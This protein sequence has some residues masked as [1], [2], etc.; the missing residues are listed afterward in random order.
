MPGSD[1]IVV[2]MSAAP[3]VCEPVSVATG[4]SVMGSLYMLFTIGVQAGREETEGGAQVI[5][6][7]VSDELDD[8][9]D[10]DELNDSEEAEL[11]SIG[12]VGSYC[13]EVAAAPL[14]VALSP[15][16]I[17]HCPSGCSGTT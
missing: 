17:G 14:V 11:D 10:S 12:L 6:L 8:P 5:E 9:N 16:V 15:K 13:G 3:A 1:E 7:E 4:T 2:I